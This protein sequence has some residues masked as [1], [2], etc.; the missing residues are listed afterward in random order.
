MDVVD[1]DRGIGILRRGGRGGGEDE[2]DQ[3]DDAVK[4]AERSLA[5]AYN[6][7]RAGTTTY[8]EVV[9]AQSVAL[10]NQRDAV[11]IATRRLTASVLLIKAIGG[12]WATEP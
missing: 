7:Y 4:S 5:L 10:A 11:D 2:A 8:L 1:V 3:Q 9:T 12:G 6:R